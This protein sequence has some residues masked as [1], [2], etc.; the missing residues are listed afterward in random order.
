MEK[1]KKN[2]VV[3]RNKF[4]RTALVQPK[5]GP[6]AAKQEFKKE[7]DIN[8][9]MSRYQKTGTLPEIAMN[10]K[11]QFGDF[12]QIDSFKE[13]QDAVIEAQGKFEGLP[14]NIRARFQNNPQALIDFMSDPDANYEEGVA[15]GLFIPVEEL[16]AI[17]DKEKQKEKDQKEKGKELAPE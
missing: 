10:G 1:N 14:S 3:V 4:D 7:C 12:T 11:G 6:S 8:H 15:L 2:K 17:K 13:A 5:G 16:E 9:I